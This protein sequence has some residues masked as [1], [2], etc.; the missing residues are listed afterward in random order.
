MSTPSESK[1]CSRIFMY[2]QSS[3]PKNW[4]EILGVPRYWGVNL[5]ASGEE[6]QCDQ[7]E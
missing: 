3:T 5:H 1:V 4:N 6:T 7:R 2:V